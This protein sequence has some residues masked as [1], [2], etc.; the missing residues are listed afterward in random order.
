MDKSDRRI[1][2]YPGTFDPIT[3]G[4]AGLVRRGLKMFDTVV[5]AVAAVSTKTPLFD[6]DERVAMAKEVFSGEPNVVVEP[7]SG[8]LMRYADERGACALLR[9]LRAISDF[10]FEFQTA[11]MNRHMNQDIET[12]FLMSD[13][14]WLYTSS[15][16]V[17]TVAGLGGNVSKLVPPPVFVKLCERFGE[18][19]YD[20]DDIMSSLQD[21]QS[22]AELTPLR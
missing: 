20:H 2:I 4:H 12:I 18:P 10:D 15:T 3:N 13:F 7:F 16:I 9:G 1:A 5:F 8:L 14:R 6:L 22:R 21:A 17:K 19:R 11:L